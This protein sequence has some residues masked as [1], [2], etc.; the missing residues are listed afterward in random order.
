MMNKLS[1]I[2]VVCALLAVGVFW[3]HPYTQIWAGL[4]AFWAFLS[5][6][7]ERRL[8]IVNRNLDDLLNSLKE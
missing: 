3:G 7:Y 4:C 1:L 2:T 5:W 6:T 8:S